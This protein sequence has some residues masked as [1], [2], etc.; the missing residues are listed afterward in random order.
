MRKFIRTGKVEDLK[1]FFDSEKGTD[2]FLLSGV[3]GWNEREVK[4]NNFKTFEEMDLFLRGFRGWL[5]EFTME[6]LP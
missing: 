5:M 1:E 2:V 6:G 4:I 3:G